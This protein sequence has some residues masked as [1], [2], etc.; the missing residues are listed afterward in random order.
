MTFLAFITF[1]YPLQSVYTFDIEV[2]ISG[3]YSKDAFPTDAPTSAPAPTAPTG[4]PTPP[5]VTAT[6]APTQA[7]YGDRIIDYYEN[8]VFEFIEENIDIYAPNCSSIN[9]TITNSV[10]LVTTPTIV[11][12]SN[13]GMTVNSTNPGT[14]NATLS[15]HLEAD[16]SFK[17]MTE[18]GKEITDNKVDIE[19]AVLAE[20]YNEA[21]PD[22]TGYWFKLI[23]FTIGNAANSLQISMTALFITAAL[24]V[25]LL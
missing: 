16:Q 12:D 18:C 21:A 2:S 10:N 3:N 24:S 25:M 13:P 15:I 1:I 4:T 8:K 19:T 23:N 9:V 20:A 17:D 5:P 11:S 22:D 6:P 7:A 14:F